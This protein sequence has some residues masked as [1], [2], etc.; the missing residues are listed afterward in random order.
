ML[1]RRLSKS[2]VIWACRPAPRRVRQRV[3][4]IYSRR[5]EEPKAACQRKPTAPLALSS[6]ERLNKKPFACLPT[7]LRPSGPVQQRIF[8][9]T[10]KE[11]T[12]LPGLRY[13]SG[14][15][16]DCL[17]ILSIQREV[18]TT[19]CTVFIHRRRAHDQ[20]QNVPV[21]GR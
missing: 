21:T 2:S 20:P 12:P 7:A 15:R 3:E 14:H 5:S 11:L 17:K 10:E 6:T 1:R 8:H 19:D 9:Q 4:S 18:L 16:R 13:S